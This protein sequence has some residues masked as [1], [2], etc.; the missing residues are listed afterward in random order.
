[1]PSEITKPINVP[2]KKSRVLFTSL[3]AVGDAAVI[4]GMLVLSYWLYF[5]TV[6]TP[7]G[8]VPPFMQYL[9]IYPLATLVMLVSFRYFGL[10]KRQ[11]SLLVSSEVGKVAKAM[12]AGMVTLI[13]FTFLFKQ[14][15]VVTVH[16]KMDVRTVEYSAGVWLIS[17]VLTTIAVTGWRKGFG[18]LEIWYYRRKGL[19]KRLLLV[20][21]N[22]RAEQVCRGIKSNPQLCYEVVGAVSTEKKASVRAVDGVEVVGT[23]ADFDGLVEGGGIDE[24][25]LCV[26]D[27]PRDVK[28]ELILKC[29]REMVDFRLVPD[30]FEVLTSNV[31]VVGIDGVPLMGLRPL[32][33]D[34]AWNRFV[35]RARSISPGR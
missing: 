13:I 15:V 17:L 10:Y 21:T 25:I 22:E 11:W 8:G 14:Q 28:G 32:P 31:E 2:R 6:F 1:M 19:N 4:F 30:L 26:T 18:R 34:S 20:G 7:R 35:K 24:V 33:L 9:R 29:E 27:L 5:D 12:V 16:G 3:L 23:L